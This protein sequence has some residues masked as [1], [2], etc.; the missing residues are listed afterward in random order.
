MLFTLIRSLYGTHRTWFT[1]LVMFAAKI[2]SRL[3][4]I[5]ASVSPLVYCFAEG[6]D[7]SRRGWEKEDDR[8]RRPRV[9]GLSWKT[10]GDVN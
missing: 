6:L 8:V 3:D 1:R 9:S 5:W 2:A 7:F 4:I 10:R